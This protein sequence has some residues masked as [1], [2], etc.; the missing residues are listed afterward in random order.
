[1]S[2]I[3]NRP[4]TIAEGIEVKIENDQ[5]VVSTGSKQLSQIIFPG[6]EV[7][8]E[9]GK[10]L[11]A[12]KVGTLDSRAK[13]G[14]LRT[15]IDNMIIGLSKGFKK[16]L[17]VVG[18]GYKASIS[19]T[20]LTLNLGYSHPIEYQAPEGIIID[21]NADTITVSGD[22]KQLVGQVASEIRRFRSPEPYKGKGIRYSDEKIV[23]KPGKT[24]K[25]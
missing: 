25:A 15:L 4:V 16:E 5:I 21:V 11:V 12:D 20:K 17:K 6:L 7:R 2:R 22:Q 13:H 24:G 23:L 1:M 10:I 9:D 14:L 3:G 18:V 19:G 8:M